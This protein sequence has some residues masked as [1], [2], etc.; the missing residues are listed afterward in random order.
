MKYPAIAVTKIDTATNRLLW[1][2]K[3]LNVVVEVDS[4]VIMVSGIGYMVV[5]KTLIILPLH[6]Q[7]EVHV[8]IQGSWYNYSKSDGNFRQVWLRNM[9]DADGNFRHVW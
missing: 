1:F 5:K 9:T 8:R 4:A 3:I 7:A 6:F 2:L